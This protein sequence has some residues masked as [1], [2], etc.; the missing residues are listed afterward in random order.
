[1]NWQIPGEETGTSV[2]LCWN[3]SQSWGNA[4]MSVYN[5]A[6]RRHLGAGH[7]GSGGGRTWLSSEAVLEPL[8]AG[9]LH[10]AGLVHP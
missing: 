4:V 1:M 5:P 6:H 10:P 3:L 8:V 7:L 2:E 9:A